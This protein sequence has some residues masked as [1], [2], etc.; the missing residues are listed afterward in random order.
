MVA[1]EAGR[2][3]IDVWA[4]VPAGG[5]KIVD[6]AASQAVLRPL[7][8]LPD[9]G[10][11][12]AGQPLIGGQ[13]V[14]YV[15]PDVGGAGL[16]VRGHAVV[17]EHV[18]TMAATIYPETPA[19]VTVRLTASAWSAHGAGTSVPTQQ[20]ITFSWGDAQVWG[21]AGHSTIWPVGTQ[22]TH[23]APEAATAVAFWPRLSTGMH[24]LQAAHAARLGGLLWSAD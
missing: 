11:W 20:P 5:T 3:L 8:V 9:L 21:P 19:H 2:S 23:G 18:V 17:G 10:V 4:E 15:A 13:G 7:P 12:A 16:V 14:T 1:S 6:L 22:I 24:D